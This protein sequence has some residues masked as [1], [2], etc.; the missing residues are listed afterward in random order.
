MN[1]VT[2]TDDPLLGQV[3]ES[4]KVESLTTS[5]Q[6][7]WAGCTAGYIRSSA[8]RSPSRVLKADYADDP[9]WCS[10]SFAKRCTV[11]AIRH[12]AIVDIF[13]FGTLATAISR[14]S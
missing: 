3:V 6:G 9:G 7:R 13:G 14:T 11:N 8:G 2:V 1:L 10:G 5:A 12:P 4:Y